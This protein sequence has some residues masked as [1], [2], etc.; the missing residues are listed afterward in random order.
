MEGGQSR[1]VARCIVSCRL[2]ADIRRFPR[3]G[4]ATRQHP[5]AQRQQV[6]RHVGLQRRD[7]VRHRGGDQLRPR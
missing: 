3:L 1:K 6:R 2:V 4:D 7:N 5:R